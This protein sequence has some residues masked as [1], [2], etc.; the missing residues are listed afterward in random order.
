MSLRE[1][2]LSQKMKLFQ[3]YTQWVSDAALDT[4]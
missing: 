2:Q 3:L 4:K 1:I